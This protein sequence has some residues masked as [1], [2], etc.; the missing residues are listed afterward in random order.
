MK[1]KL[2]SKQIYIISG[3]VFAVIAVLFVF[4]AWY[5]LGYSLRRG[6]P[7]EP[8][9]LANYTVVFENMDGTELSVR[10]YQEGERVEIPPEPTM[11]STAQYDYTFTGWDREIQLTAQSDVRYVAQ[12][13]AQIRSYFV[14]FLSESG[15]ELYQTYVEYGSSVVYPGTAPKKETTVQ[16]T[17]TFAGWSEDTS[18]ITGETTVTPVFDATVNRYPITFLNEDGSVYRTVDVPYGSD[19]AEYCD[20]P[21]KPSDKTYSYEFTGWSEDV[22]AIQGAMTV[23]AQYQAAYIPYVISFKYKDAQGAEQVKTTEYHYGDTIEEP[24]VSGSVLTGGTVAYFAGWDKEP[25]E[26]VEVSAIFNAVYAAKAPVY[27][28]S[29]EYF[30]EDGSPAAEPYEKECVYGESYRVLSPVIPYYTGSALLYD[31]MILRS[32]VSYTVIY[33]FDGFGDRVNGYYQIRSA[34][35]LMALIHA[36]EAWSESFRLTADIA[37]NGDWQ[38]IGTAD[39]P[40]TGVFDGNGYTISGINLVWDGTLNESGRASVGFFP[41]LAGSVTNLALDATCELSLR[42]NV[43]VGLLVGTVTGGS[44]QNCTVTGRLSVESSSYVRAGILAGVAEKGAQVKNNVVQAELS[45]ASSV[46]NGVSTDAFV[47]YADASAALSDNE[48]KPLQGAEEPT[49]PEEPEE[50]ETSDTSDTSSGKA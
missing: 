4:I 48:E 41:V 19:A 35:Q 43:S 11:A 33:S 5:T 39:T 15:T 8:P 20:S 12:Y 3:V 36:P 50:D 2:N 27:T 49:V 47:G 14:T 16:Y 13:D 23:T 17:Y 30:Y 37:L 18:F 31:G 28:L 26:T 34:E 32:S 42:E 7:E 6:E 9:V 38:G 25:G 40:F 29:I 22:S 24:I 45:A 1:Q 10:T 21:E 44:V 46:A